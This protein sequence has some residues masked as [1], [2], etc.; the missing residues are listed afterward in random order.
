MKRS[1][2]RSREPKI[3]MDDFAD[4]IKRGLYWQR[5]WNPVTGC[6]PISRGCQNCWAK[7][8]AKRF[9]ADRTFADV[10]F[11]ADRLDQ[12][13]HW[14]TPS[15]VAVCFMGDLFHEDVSERD[16]QNVLITAAACDRHAFIF[17]TKR[18]QRMAAVIHRLRVSD[19]FGPYTLDH[20]WFGVSVE[21]QETAERRIPFL[22]RIPSINRV[23]SY[24]PALGAVDF[25]CHTEMGECDA[26][27]NWMEQIDWIV[28]GAESGPNPRPALPEWFTAAHRQCRV[29]GIPFFFKSWGSGPRLGSKYK[30][31]GEIVRELPDEFCEI[32][33]T[34][35]KGA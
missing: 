22:L 14:K 23:I 31:E 10:R 24:E 32:I 1:E 18:P 19:R 16:V 30:L 17:L 28:A 27:G 12:P 34:P 21:D 9:W 6:T 11:H 2:H 20:M 13:F 35:V 7:S 33:G 26:D 8:M 25:D 4:R 3:K 29:A 15:V 5:A